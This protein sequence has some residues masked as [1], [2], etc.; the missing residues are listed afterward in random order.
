MWKIQRE[1]L[2][3]LGSFYLLLLYSG[4]S[5]SKLDEEMKFVGKN[6]GFFLPSEKCNAN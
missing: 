6:A 1:I 5:Y 3:K 2:I 4:Y